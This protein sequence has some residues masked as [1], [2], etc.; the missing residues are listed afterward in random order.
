MVLNDERLFLSGSWLGPRATACFVHLAA[1]KGID[2]MAKGLAGLQTLN[3]TLLEST[4][5]LKRRASDSTVRYSTIEQLESTIRFS[6][7]F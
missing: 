1:C 7:I 2:T 5:A 4:L 6:T 3:T